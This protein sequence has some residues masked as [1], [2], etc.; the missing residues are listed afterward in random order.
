MK[1]KSIP[2]PSRLERLPAELIRAVLF[3]LDCLKTLYRAVLSCRLLWHSFLRSS[4]GIKTR[5]VLNDLDTCDVRP[6]A[7]AVLQAS[8]LPEATLSSV[9]EFHTLHLSKR[10]VDSSASLTLGEVITVAKLHYAI[11]RLANDFAKRYINVLPKPT[12][13]RHA[14]HL[15]E[16]SASERRRV[17]RVLYTLEIFFNLFRRTSMSKVEEAKCMNEFLVSF[18]PWEIEQ[19]A[20]V[21]EF[22]VLHISPLNRDIKR[23]EGNYLR[24]EN[25]AE[26]TGL[27]YQPHVQAALFLGLIFLESIAKGAAGYLRMHDFAYMDRVLPSWPRFLHTAL[28]GIDFEA[29]DYYKYVFVSSFRNARDYALKVKPPFFE[30]PDDGPFAVWK[31]THEL[32]PVNLSVYRMNNSR[33]DW[34][35]VMWDRDRLDAYRIL[36]DPWQRPAISRNLPTNSSSREINGE[37]WISSRREASR[38]DAEREEDRWFNFRHGLKIER[39]TPRPE[40]ASPATARDTPK[41]LDE[42]RRAILALKR[43]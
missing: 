32:Y 13:N 26:S 36:Q 25:W 2:R 29:I 3:E 19:M 20:C 14:P 6:E 21:H 31:Q 17:M 5:V 38:T 8:R 10:R 34:A 27:Y 12:G 35:Y 39:M 40:N 22:L 1:T 23:P 7:L 30:D 4:S 15:P 9:R 41:S 24:I 16:L 28:R 33:L 37:R 11:S 43:P 18:A 42:A